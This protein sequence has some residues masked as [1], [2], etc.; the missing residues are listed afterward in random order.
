MSV[1]DS[2][3]RRVARIAPGSGPEI[4]LNSDGEIRGLLALALVFGGLGKTRVRRVLGVSRSQ[5]YL[6][7]RRA[8]RKLLE[9]ESEPES[10]AS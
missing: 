2:I 7:M 4:D 9:P 6:D 1:V 3:G 8:K 10:L 5:M